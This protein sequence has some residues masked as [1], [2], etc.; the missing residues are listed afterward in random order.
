MPIFLC[1]LWNEVPG[2]LAQ[3]DILLT[4]EGFGTFDGD[5]GIRRFFADWHRSLEGDGIGTMTLH[6]L[7]TEIIEVAGNGRPRGP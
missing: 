2:M 5:A 6:P 3:R 4:G 7:T 1:Q